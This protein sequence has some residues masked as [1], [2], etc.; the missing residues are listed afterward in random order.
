MS[1][2]CSGRDLFGSTIGI[3]YI[4]GICNETGVGIVQDDSN[5]LDDVAVTM[6]HELGHLFSMEHDNR[7]EYT[8]ID[9]A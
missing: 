4:G 7:R 2:L 1:L 5:S 8:L 9:S 3:A 6:A